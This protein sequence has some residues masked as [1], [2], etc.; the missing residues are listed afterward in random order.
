MKV[1]AVCVFI[2]LA[3][4]INS[5]C[6]TDQSNSSPA[7]GD[8]TPNTVCPAPLDMKKAEH[9]AEVSYANAS[10]EVREYVIWTAKSFGRRGMWFNED[11]FAAMTDAQRR[12]KIESIAALLKDAEYGRHLCLALA[13]AAALKDDSLVPGLMKVAGYHVDGRDYDCRLKWMAVAALAR[14]ESGDAVPLLVSLTDHGNLNVRMWARA[15]LSRK[16]GQDFKDDKQAWDKWWRAQGNAP[17][18]GKFLK[19]W[20]AVLNN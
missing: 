8:N 7:K 4:S 20:E 14:Q 1:F 3:A 2:I 5:V 6:Q 16:T 19:P 17:I 11:A 12:K 13:E 9:E 10:P 18:D 15:A